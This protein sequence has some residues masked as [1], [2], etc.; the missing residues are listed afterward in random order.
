M[1]KHI[2]SG[3]I[4]NDVS[5]K[6]GYAWFTINGIYTPLKEELFNEHYKKIN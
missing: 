6:D 1:Y 2:R 3:T 5:F 4:V